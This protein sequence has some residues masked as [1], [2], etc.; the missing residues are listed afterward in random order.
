MDKECTICGTELRK[1][2]NPHTIQNKPCW[3]CKIKNQFVEEKKP[4]ENLFLKNSNKSTIEL[5]NAVNED[6]HSIILESS[7]K[8]IESIENTLSRNVNAASQNYVSFIEAKQLE[9]LHGL[10][11]KVYLFENVHTLIRSPKNESAA[12]CIFT[13][14]LKSEENKNSYI[15]SFAPK[16]GLAIKNEAFENDSSLGLSVPGSPSGGIFNSGPKSTPGSNA[17]RASVAAVM[18]L[19]LLLCLFRS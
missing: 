5:V 10:F 3:I 2:S 11:H 17:P 6:T 19:N 7:D 18:E 15:D 16:E 8:D 9:K 13:Y 12:E 1:R 4:A 14:N